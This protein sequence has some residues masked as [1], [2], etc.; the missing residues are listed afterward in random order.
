MKTR[1]IAEL[2]LADQAGLDKNKVLRDV[3]GAEGNI[4]DMVAIARGE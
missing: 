3:F 2:M 1:F 4:N